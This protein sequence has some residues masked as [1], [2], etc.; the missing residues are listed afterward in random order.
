MPKETDLV[1]D[2]N[3]KRYPLKVKLGEDEVLFLL[4]KE[5][6]PKFRIY[7]DDLAREPSLGTPKCVEV[8]PSPLGETVGLFTTKDCL[9]GDLLFSE[10][11]MVSAISSCIIEQI[12][13][14]SFQVVLP[15]DENVKLKTRWKVYLLEPFL[16]T[17]TERCLSPINKARFMSLSASIRFETP[18]SEEKSSDSSDWP[19]SRIFLSNPLGVYFRKPSGQGGP[20]PQEKRV[21]MYVCF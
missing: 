2:D 15:N 11:P 6:V 13:N 3:T 5:D 10:R 20:C 1:Y 14:A 9:P 7:L 21:F 16:Q 4:K 17:V 12:K 18:T 8:R 19:K